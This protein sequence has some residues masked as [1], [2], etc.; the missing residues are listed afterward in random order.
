MIKFGDL[1]IGSL[2]KYQGTM[3]NKITK[4]T[5]ISATA[6]SLSFEPEEEIKGIVKMKVIIE[7]ISNLYKLVELATESNLPLIAS[8]GSY[9]VCASSIMGLCSLDLREPIEIRLNNAYDHV[10]EYQ[11][12]AFDNFCDK[13]SKFSKGE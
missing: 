5:A 2:F 8:Q 12:W 1:G 11:E 7:T 9:V 4:N 3:Y 10:S 6:N 13:Y